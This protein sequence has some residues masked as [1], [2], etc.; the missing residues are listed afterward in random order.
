MLKSLKLKEFQNH[1]RSE[2]KFSEG[3]NVIRGASD[4]GK[5]AI[6]RGLR[7]IVEN[8]PTGEG[9]RRTDG[10]G[11]NTVVEATFG[12]DIVKR[13]KG[14]KNIYILN[15]QE[16]KAVGTGIPKEISDVID[17]NDTNHQTQFSPHI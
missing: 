10:E 8:R 5:S 2:L 15:G 7:W 14:K 4:N 6:I 11:N 17:F 16:Y 1:E 13:V 12:H 9:F 3:L